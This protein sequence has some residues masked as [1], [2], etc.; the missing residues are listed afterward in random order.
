MRAFGLIRP[1]TLPEPLSLD[2]LASAD[3]TSEERAE[4]ALL[5]RALAAL[6]APDRV[7][8]MLRCVEGLSIDEV[9][10]ACSCSPATA[11]RRVA[12]ARDVVVAHLGIGGG[13][14]DDV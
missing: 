1:G 7:A 9:A 5:D 2:A 10:E 3:A 11:K 6:D 14:G 13:G 8:W 4:L 12:R